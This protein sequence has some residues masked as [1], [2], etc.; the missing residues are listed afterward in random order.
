[1]KQRIA[2]WLLVV[3]VVHVVG[4][5]GNPAAP[6][7]LIGTDVTLY[8]HDGREVSGELLAEDATSFRL[9]THGVGRATVDKSDVERILARGEH[10]DPTP[11]AP[12]AARN[13]VLGVAI[14]LAIAS[15]IAGI[16]WLLTSKGG[17]FHM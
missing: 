15:F 9:D 6:S 14:P 3:M 4:C 17:G 7:S 8:L 10:E 1:M 13:L 5:A 16:A 11:R 2:K 12:H